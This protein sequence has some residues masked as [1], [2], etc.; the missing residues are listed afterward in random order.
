[1][2][3]PSPASLRGALL[4]DIVQSTKALT[5]RYLAGFND[6][7]HVR[8]TPDLPNHVAWQLGHL[9]LTMHRVAAMLDGAELPPKDFV[10]GDGYAGSREKG[11]YDAE[12]VA[13]ASRPEER[14]DRFPKLDRCVEI[15]NAAADRLSAALRAA[16]DDQLDKTVPWGQTTTPLWA[17]ASRRVF[18]NGFHTGQI[19]DM[20][21]ALSFKSVFA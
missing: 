4:A 19:A 1:M 8:Q 13:F 10:K 15:F 12:A 9:A 5:A 20:R 3:T 2:S 6:V 21:R 16:T 14:H 17:L 11:H 18:H 7:T